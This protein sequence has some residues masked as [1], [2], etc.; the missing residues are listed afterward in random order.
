MEHYA[1]VFSEALGRLIRYRSVPLS[2]WAQ[3]LRELGVPTHLVDHLT[4][5]AELHRQGRYDRITDDLFSITGKPPTSM[6][7]FVKAHAAEFARSEA[8]ACGA[9]RS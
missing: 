9:G 2:W 6:Y 4:V 3:R 8:T 5:M 7:D 1:S